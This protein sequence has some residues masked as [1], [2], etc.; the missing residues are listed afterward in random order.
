MVDLVASF[1][2]S[3]AGKSSSTK[4]QARLVASAFTYMVGHDSKKWTRDNVYAYLQKNEILG[5]STQYN[6]AVQLRAFLRFHGRQDL[7][8]LVKPPRRLDAG[9]EYLGVAQVEKILKVAQDPRDQL[10]IQVLFHTGLRI[11]EVTHLE[12]GDVDLEKRVIK[13]QAKGLWFPKGLK[14]RTVPV[15]SSTA[16]MIKEYLGERSTGRIFEI[17]DTY[18]RRLIKD[19]VVKA[20]ISQVRVT[21]HIF[22]HSFAVHF[23]KNGGD[24]RSLQKILGHSDLATT[25]MYLSYTDKDV[26]ESYDKVFEVKKEVEA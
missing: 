1:V 5:R 3:Y 24:L 2:A 8:E 6:Y 13:I 7:A 20:G 21:P 15:D 26:A 16:R 14:E 17:S 25:A 18:A 22:R 23:L 12:V 10:L 11:G 9:K 4:Q 19:L